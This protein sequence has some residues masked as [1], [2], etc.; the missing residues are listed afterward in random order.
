MKDQDIM[1]PKLWIQAAVIFAISFLFARS[2][3]AEGGVEDLAQPVYEALTEGKY[4]YAAALGVILAVALLRR[5]GGAKWPIVAHPLVAP[6]LVVI[7]GMGSALL[8]S[9]AADEPFNVRDLWAALKI[10]AG[11][12][13]IYALT[14]PYFDAA[15]GKAPGWLQPIMSILAS[16]YKTKEKARQAEVKAAIEKVEATHKSPGTGIDFKDIK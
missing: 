14:K 13:G 5:Y 4:A 7:T 2:A 6:V 12:A 3:A 10:S 11:A 15:Q 9:Y 16:L 1:T 8:S